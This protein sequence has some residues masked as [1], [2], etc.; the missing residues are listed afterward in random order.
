MADMFRKT[1]EILLEVRST[2]RGVKENSIILSAES[3]YLVRDADFSGY[4]L[5]RGRKMELFLIPDGLN[6]RAHFPPT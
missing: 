2:Y 6:W 4:R 5:R 1:R 3:T